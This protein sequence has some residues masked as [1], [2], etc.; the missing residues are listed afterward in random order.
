MNNCSLVADLIPFK[1]ACQP[2]PS[3]LYDIS[4]PSSIPLLFLLKHAFSFLFFRSSISQF[5]RILSFPFSKFV[6]HS[7]SF[8]FSFS[9]CSI[10]PLNFFLQNLKQFPGSWIPFWNSTDENSAFN[11]RVELNL[12]SHCR[13]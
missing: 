10:L 7:L 9:N 12:S 3:P 13:R 4:D 5:F 2:P 8:F 1:G 11:V 6:R